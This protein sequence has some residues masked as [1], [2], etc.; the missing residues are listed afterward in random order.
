MAISP[1]VCTSGPLL[2]DNISN[3]MIL[4][5]QLMDITIQNPQNAVLRALN[6]HLDFKRPYLKAFWSFPQT[7]QKETFYDPMAN[8]TQIK[9]AC[10][11]KSA[12]LLDRYSLYQV[13]STKPGHRWKRPTGK[14][15]FSYQTHWHLNVAFVPYPSAGSC[16]LVLWLLCVLCCGVAAGDAGW[17]AGWWELFHHSSCLYISW[18]RIMLP[19][20]SVNFAFPRAPSTSWWSLLTGSPHPM[21]QSS[22][23][24]NDG[25]GPLFSTLFWSS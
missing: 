1:P 3:S 19:C 13:I 18:V 5:S 23:E 25:F 15:R 7:Q 10:G 8:I 21:L 2:F 16:A 14:N 17:W 9:W 22:S 4:C 20:R 24:Y 12:W 6:L 11:N